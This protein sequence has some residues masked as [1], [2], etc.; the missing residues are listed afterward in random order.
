[1]AKGA[2]R[3]L[4]FFGIFDVASPI[5]TYMHIVISGDSDD[6]FSDGSIL[7]VRF[8]ALHLAF[9]SHFIFYFLHNM[10]T[11]SNFNFDRL[12]Y[13]LQYVLRVI[14]HPCYPLDY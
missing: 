12:L 6:G 14:L 13:P 5:H 2:R 4:S 1:M 9:V 10:R 8:H 7:P 3:V 11:R